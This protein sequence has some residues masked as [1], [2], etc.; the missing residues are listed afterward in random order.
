MQ[1]GRQ[2][3]HILQHNPRLDLNA[4]ELKLKFIALKKVQL[5]KNIMQ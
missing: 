4:E 3:L 2:I 5:H 1:S